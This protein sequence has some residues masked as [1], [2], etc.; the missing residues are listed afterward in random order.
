MAELRCD[1]GATRFPVVAPDRAR[2][3]E[4]EIAVP[5][6]HGLEGDEVAD[7]GS[8]PVDV[9]AVVSERV[10]EALSAEGHDLRPEHVSVEP[11]RPVPVG[12]GDDDVVERELQS[13]RSQ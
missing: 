7:I 5:R 2:P 10:G 3:H 13:S 8:R 12:D 6:A 1:D 11:V 9:Q 4:A